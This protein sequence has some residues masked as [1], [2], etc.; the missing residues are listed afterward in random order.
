LANTQAE[1]D[2]KI[3]VALL[4]RSIET[5]EPLL[6]FF[7]WRDVSLVAFDNLKDFEAEIEGGG[8]HAIGLSLL[9]PNAEVEK[10]PSDFETLYQI[11]V[12]VFVEKPDPIATARFEEHVTLFK[13]RT[14]G[15]LDGASFET[16]VLRAIKSYKNSQPAPVKTRR[17]MDDDARI[18]VKGAKPEPLGQRLR[19]VSTT[20]AP[21]AA[22][23]KPAELA[24]QA[25]PAKLAEKHQ[26]KF[27]SA[28]LFGR[29]KR[30]D[31]EF[32]SLW[33]CAVAALRI[34]AGDTSES[35]EA[36]EGVSYCALLSLHSP[37]AQG[38]FVLMLGPCDGN[39][40]ELTS[41]MVQ[42]IIRQMKILEL[43]ILKPS[44]YEVV[45]VKSELVKDEVLGRA[46]FRSARSGVIADMEVI[47][48]DHCGLIPT[49]SG[50]GK[51]WQ[52]VP[53]L[54]IEPNTV[55]DFK[56]AVALPTSNRIVVYLN[57][58]RSLNENQLARLLVLGVRNVLIEE[59]DH[60]LY[61]EYVARQSMKKEL[62]SSFRPLKL[63][64]SA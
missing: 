61:L 5:V 37:L 28:K 52:E 14:T 57:E 3:K 22:K 53:L 9:F 7:R 1:T 25:A 34:V 60:L 35:I 63:K 21:A 49:E 24:A 44:E 38:T 56:V 41:Q 40:E 8:F 23:A 15:P 31:A 11:P 62:P 33:L 26:K 6:K 43:G 54:S 51:S 16:C 13:Y 48:V 39:E 58:N 30:T 45:V 19:L 46:R 12:I 10:M 42:E 18:F 2:E 55:V 47:Y 29:S 32:T 4:C 50:A 20:E 64:L 27:Q 17:P 36:V 59:K